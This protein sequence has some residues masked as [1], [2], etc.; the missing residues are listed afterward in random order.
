MSTVPTADLIAVIIGVAVVV[1]AVPAS[2]APVIIVVAIV[3]L[4][5]VSVVLGHNDCCRE[6]QT[7]NC[8]RASSEPGLN[9]HVTP[10]VKSARIKLTETPESPTGYGRPRSQVSPFLRAS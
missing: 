6:D 9:R 8:S 7:Q 3:L 10:Y 4:V 2:M 5:A 1:M